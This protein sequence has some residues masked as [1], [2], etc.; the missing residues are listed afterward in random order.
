[1]PLEYSWNQRYGSDDEDGYCEEQFFELWTLKPL[2]ELTLEDVLWCLV[3]AASNPFATHL[4]LY[5]FIGTQNAYRSARKRY[6][7]LMQELE[8]QFGFSPSEDGSDFLSSDGD[9]SILIS[10]FTEDETEKIFA[11]E[12]YV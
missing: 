2:R 1:M 4:R 7:A 5:V 8:K 6:L 3:A 12:Q 10:L 9:F 11:S